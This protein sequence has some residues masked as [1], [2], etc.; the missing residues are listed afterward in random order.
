MD[1]TISKYV[2][3]DREISGCMSKNM[4]RKIEGDSS[5]GMDRTTSANGFDP[6]MEG[7][8]HIFLN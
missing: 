2:N 4:D 8:P 3:T 1:G 5:E 7:Y 6:Q